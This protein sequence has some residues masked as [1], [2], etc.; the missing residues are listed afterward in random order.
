MVNV[1]NSTQ[2]FI[3]KS[4]SNTAM[5]NTILLETCLFSD[6]TL[7]SVLFLS[8]S[9][10]LWRA[11]IVWLQNN[12]HF[13]I[14][15]T[16]CIFTTWMIGH[17]ITCAQWWLNYNRVQ[18]IFCANQFAQSKWNQL[19]VLNL[20]AQLQ[21]YRTQKEIPTWENVFWSEGSTIL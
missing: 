11:V 20:L 21:L 8:S 18:S 12:Q 14:L 4:H 13:D 2:N 1:I 10:R 15:F 9:Y 16:S 5:K 19:R 17:G 6:N 3:N 7:M